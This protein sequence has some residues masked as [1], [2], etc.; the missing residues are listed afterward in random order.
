MLFWHY[1]HECQA[2]MTEQNV[3][4]FST[5]K[6]KQTNKIQIQIQIVVAINIQ[7]EWNDNCSNQNKFW[8][9]GSSDGSWC[10]KIYGI[11]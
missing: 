11:V 3:Q 2:Q 5:D 7:R 6:N 4:P 9:I 8:F 10:L 1:L